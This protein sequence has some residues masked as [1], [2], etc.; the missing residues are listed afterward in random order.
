MLAVNTLKILGE[1][2]SAFVV[3]VEPNPICINC[4]MP[5][6]GSYIESGRCL[7]YPY[8]LADRPSG[9]KGK[10]YVTDNDPGCSSL[11]VPTQKFQADYQ[12]P[13]IGYVEIE[14][15]TL[16]DVFE[17]SAVKNAHLVDF[18]K[19]DA[20]GS[21]LAVIRGGRSSLTDKTVVVTIECGDTDYIGSDAS[22]ENVSEEMEYLGFERTFEF[23]TKDPTFLNTKFRSLAR[24]VI[25]YQ[26]N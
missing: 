23:D 1:C 26:H 13:L 19:I 5:H 25:A 11:Y 14:Y 17:L 22:I 8:A 3:A 18:I 16:N 12:R 9:E 7:L 4:N 2:P 24:D 6:L 10:L 15:R 20:Q 21:D